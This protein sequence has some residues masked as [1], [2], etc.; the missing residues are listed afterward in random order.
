MPKIRVDYDDWEEADEELDATFERIP[1]RRKSEEEVKER[2]RK[3]K[4]RDPE[5][6]HR[7]EFQEGEE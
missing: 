4:H 1:N 6:I 2:I 7:K 3:E 5:A